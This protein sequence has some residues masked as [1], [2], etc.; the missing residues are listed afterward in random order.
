MQLHGPSSAHR[1][2]GN[3]VVGLLLTHD[4]EEQVAIVLEGRYP[5]PCANEVRQRIG[6]QL[7][8]VDASGSQGFY[9]SFNGHR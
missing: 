7:H 9:W 6:V 4:G 5:Q 8:E 2:V 3:E 1:E